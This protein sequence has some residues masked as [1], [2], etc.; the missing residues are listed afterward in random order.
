MAQRLRAEGITQ[1]VRL[2]GSRTRWAAIGVAVVVLTAVSLLRTEGPAIVRAN[3]VMIG[4]SLV[5]RPASWLPYAVARSEYR[6]TWC[7]LNNIRDCDKVSIYDPAFASAWKARRAAQ[8]A[9]MRRPSWSKW[10][11]RKPDLRNAALRSAF[12]VGADLRRARMDGAKL[13]GAHL[14]GADLKNARLSGVNLKS[15]QV[16][17]VNL[18]RT[19]MDGVNLFGAQMEGAV[20]N[21]ALLAGTRNDPSKMKNTNLS[22]VES[23]GSALRFVDLT[24]AVFDQRT[25]FRNAFLDASVAM[26]PEFRAQMGHPCQWTD[27]VLDDEAFFGRWRGWTEA[28]PNSEIYWK[29]L[30]PAGFWTVAAIPPPEGCAWKAESAETSRAEP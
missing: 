2:I 16:Q 22:A 15:A 14:E 30:A 5:E 9:E 8:I 4:A 7:S 20:I 24:E 26:T 13:Q 21:Y 25:D 27:A 23:K 1:H 19:R 10:L 28:G 3:P 11:A 6:A 17:G 18:S 29:N 12:L